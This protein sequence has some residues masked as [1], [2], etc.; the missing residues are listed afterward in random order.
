MRPEPNYEAWK[1]RRSAARVPEGFAD[2]VMSALRQEP[3]P[4]ARTWRGIGPELERYL[5]ALLASRLG[6]LGICTLGCLA[7]TFRMLSLIALF[8]P[9]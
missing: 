8:L 5:T 3:A 6:K 2:R 9:R 4:R 7:C 1:R